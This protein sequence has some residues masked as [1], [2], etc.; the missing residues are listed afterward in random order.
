M[1]VFDVDWQFL[2][3]HTLVP[4]LTAAAA[5]GLLVT[6]LWLHGQTTALLAELNSNQDAIHE[7][8]QALVYRR[9]LVD[10]YHRRYDKFQELGF[11]G[12]ESRLDW[13][14]TMREASTD[15]TLPR[16]SFAIGPQLD[17]VAPVESVRTGNGTSLH[18]SRLQVQMG[19]VH[20]ID[21]LRFFDDLQTKAPGLITVDRC[22]LEWQS[23][24]RSPLDVRANIHADCSILIFSVIT[25]DVAGGVA[26]L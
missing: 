10:R 9:R 16:V 15:L 17:V 26:K 25:S 8:Y 14:E 23:D 1:Q 12:T 20:E 19:L 13:I 3:R 4:V 5:A 21:L 7:D 11:V 24:P 22:D 2:V 6:G 18:L